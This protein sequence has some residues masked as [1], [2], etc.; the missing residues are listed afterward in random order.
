MPLPAPFAASSA[1][2]RHAADAAACPALPPS[3]HAKF[4]MLP[5]PRRFHGYAASADFV[6]A[7]RLSPP[8]LMFSL[9]DNAASDVA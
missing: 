8:S 4:A 3:S 9:L 2:F 6:D 1:I 5:P 7:G